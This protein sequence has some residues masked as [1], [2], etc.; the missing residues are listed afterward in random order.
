MRVK[1]IYKTL[2]KLTAII[3]L[4]A[5]GISC[6]TNQSDNNIISGNQ[7]LK[8]EPVQLNWIGQWKNEGL[9]GKLV[10]D[11][12][13]Q[14]EFENPD[15]KVNLKFHQDIYDEKNHLKFFSKN[16]NAQ[17]SDWDLIWING[18]A[19]VIEGPNGYTK[20]SDYLV[21]L[22]VYPE[23]VNNHRPGI[24]E[25]K[26]FK[27]KWNN[28][29][30]G[31]ALDGYDYLL[32]CNLELAKKIG[33]TVKQFDMT[34]EDFLGY[35]KA[36]QDYNTANK[37]NVYGIFDESSNL[38][39]IPMQLYCSE[40]GSFE[41]IM[42]DNL[43]ETKWAAFEKTIY[44]LEKI[45]Q[46]RPLPSD[47]QYN[48][49]D[50]KNYPLK[51]NCLFK[52]GASYMYNIWLEADSIATKNMIPVQ[53]PEFKPSQTY[54]GIYA[55]PWAIPKNSPHIE[56]AVRLLKYIASPQV[57]DQWIRYTKSPTGVQNSMVSTSM[58]M[59][60]Y[61][62][63]DYQINKKFGRTKMDPYK[64][65]ARFLSSKNAGIIL[66][67]AALVEGKISAT[68]FLNTVKKQLK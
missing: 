23:I 9:K 17:K 10:R 18:N 11:I 20:I 44:A 40:I 39:S 49:D 55:I 8:K 36:V 41:Y 34:F 46:Y 62:N 15:I 54:L 26:D 5:F 67:F 1:K 14:F 33:I 12:A 2:K 38:E 45:A 59:D 16:L 68:E 28:I 7:I 42:Q 35:L 50:D 52:V 48:W 63:F 29:L 4:T 58:G 47:K 25:K 6:S 27:V 24:L 43:D 3:L 53:L 57:A 51:G 32:W 13:R 37:T 30:P 19:E 60:P 66:D 56:E 31:V 64:G 21:D 22:S 61:E 65:N